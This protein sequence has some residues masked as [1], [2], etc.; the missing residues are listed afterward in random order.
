MKVLA[1]RPELCVACGVC[2]EICATT[3]YKVSE[4]DRSAIRITVPEASD[5]DCEI[6]FCNQC[7]E[8]IAV[9]PTQALYRAKSGIV[10]IRKKACVGCMACVG[11]CPSLAMYTYPGDI[12][13][14]KC[15][16]CGKCADD[17]PTDALYMV[18]VETPAEVTELTRSIRSKTGEGSHGS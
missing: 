7:G 14:F 10:R 11:F 9:C 15:I 3:Y 5:Q 17:C 1:A 8:C 16:A 12:L 13:P 18:E 6:A 4:R 2:E